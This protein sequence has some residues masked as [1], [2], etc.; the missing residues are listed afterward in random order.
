MDLLVRL[1]FFFFEENPVSRGVGLLRPIRAVD[2]YRTELE[3]ISI[4]SHCQHS[5]ALFPMDFF[6]FGKK[7]CHSSKV[8]TVP[9]TL[10]HSLS[11]HR[12]QALSPFLSLH[13]PR[14]SRSLLA[15]DQSRSEA[16]FSVNVLAV[17]V[18][19]LLP[20]KCLML[21]TRGSEN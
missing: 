15:A 17:A 13:F 14:Q 3:L 8:V 20:V 9:F 5:S 4:N 16:L 12:R 11:L 2:C 1:L 6:F 19:T 21:G 7:N 18:R 10:C